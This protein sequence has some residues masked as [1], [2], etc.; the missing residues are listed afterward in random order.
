MNTLPEGVFNYMDGALWSIGAEDLPEE[1]WWAMLEQT[2][3]MYNETYQADINTAE[4]ANQYLEW[5][6]KTRK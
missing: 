5:R 2:A 4:A 3:S 1:S 6:S